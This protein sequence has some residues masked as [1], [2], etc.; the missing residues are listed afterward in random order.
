MKIKRLFSLLLTIALV[1]SLAPAAFATP[2]EGDTASG[3]PGVNTSAAG[4]I[5]VNKAENG[6]T[7]KIYRILDLE[8]YNP[9]TKAYSY[10]PSDKWAN[11]F[12]DNSNTATWKTYFEK[13]DAGYVTWKSDG[14]VANLAKELRDYLTSESVEIEPED[15]KQ[16]TSTT[17]EFTNLNLGYYFLTSSVGSICSLDTTNPNATITDKNETR[18][19]VDKKVQEDSKKDAADEG[20]M[21]VNDDD[22]GKTVN[23]KTTVYLK[24]DESALVLH[25]KMDAGFTF[26]SSSVEVKICKNPSSTEPDTFENVNDSNYTVKTTDLTDNCTFEITFE[27][28]WVEDLEGNQ[29]DIEV[30]YSATLNSNAKISKEKGNDNETWLKWNNEFETEHDKTTTYTWEMSIYKYT[31][32]PEAT[33]EGAELEDGETEIKTRLAGA[34]FIIL[35]NDG[36]DTVPKYKIAE[37]TYD[38]TNPEVY[39]VSKWSEY[40]EN[41]IPD[42]SKITT[43]ADKDI[44]VKGLDSDDYELKEIKAPDGYNKLKNNVPFAVNDLT[45][46]EKDGDGTEIGVTRVE[47]KNN[48]GTE[49]PET[50]GIG[51]ALF[52]GIGSM[53]ALAACVFLVTRKKM[54]VYAE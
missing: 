46:T 19:Y 37:F 7:Y 24:G 8:S 36:T 43:V 6:A 10:K 35:R 50:G 27:E 41:S 4:Q 47:V 25:D 17:V 28:T 13:N 2:G 30:T 15:T 12:N 38:K 9:D 39:K 51:T 49:L 16:A 52:I 11:W 21:K 53:L 33:S 20:W 29:S 1:L 40:N 22:I 45:K 14:N 23:F 32:N 48:N 54:S 3:A 5:T 34:E 26:D 18:P 31:T 42:N 44:A